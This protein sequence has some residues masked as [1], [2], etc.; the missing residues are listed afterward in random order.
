ME[1]FLNL[2]KNGSKIE[3]EKEKEEGTNTI[4]EF[5]N[6]KKN[7]YIECVICLQDM[8]FGDELTMIRCSHIYHSHCIQEWMKR[9]RICPLCDSSF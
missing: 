1:A 2:F 7:D 3:K 8:K 9:K 6:Q 4:Y 5:I